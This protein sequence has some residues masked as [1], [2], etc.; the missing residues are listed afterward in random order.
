MVDR[1]DLVELAPHYV[2]MLALAFGV[3]IALRL[4]AGSLDFWIETVL[5]VLA[6]L[7]YRPAVQY[8][9]VAPSLWESD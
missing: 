8:L 4:L 7:V 2:A 1:A 5:V 3:L 6:L 9:G